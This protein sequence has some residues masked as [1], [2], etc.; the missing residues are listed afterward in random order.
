MRRIA[1]AVMA[2]LVGGGSALR[3]QTT[4][5]PNL[6]LT[7]SGG[8]TSGGELWTLPSQL[9]P[10]IGATDPNGQFDTL[11]LGRRLRP[12]VVASL[13]AT[14]H[15][16]R[17]FGYAVEVGYFGL[18]SEG[19]CEAIVPFHPDAGTPAPEMKNQQA[20]EAAQGHHFGT[21]VIAFQGGF[22]YRL[23]PAGPV[24]PYVRGTGGLAALGSSYVQ[25]ITRVLAPQGCAPTGSNTC[26]IALLV[27]PRRRSATWAGTL[28]A[29]LSWAIGTGY[30]LRLEARDFIVAVP[31]AADSTTPTTGS[32]DPVARVGTR[33]KHVLM[34][35][36][37]LDVILERRHR[38]RY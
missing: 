13:V 28:A 9:V 20:C 26:N 17:H 29:G 37:G 15:R 38:R 4:Q 2:V 11:R 16:S 8:L 12:G 35:T 30:Q 1:T 22:V 25:T 6:I 19:R 14:L 33:T 23:T 34:L 24:S 31:I 3:A 36:A 5:Q 10:V 7:I 32:P 21:N 18:D 27:Q